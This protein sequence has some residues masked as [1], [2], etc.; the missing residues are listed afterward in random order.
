VEKMK[1]L[2]AA[3]IATRVFFAVAI[4][5]TYD[6]A[7]YW[8]W[9]K[10]LALGY[11]DHP[12]MV[13]WMIKISTLFFGDTNL[14]VRFF[15]IF[16]SILASYAVYY[17]GSLAVHK[18]AGEWAAI[19]LQ[20]TLLCGIG[21]FL[22]TPDVPL[23]VFWTLTLVALFKLT[24][25]G[26]GEWWLLI[27]LCAGLGFSSKYSAVFL[28][29]GILIIALKHLKNPWLYAGG[30]LALIAASP[31]LIWNIQHDWVSFIK[32]GSRVLIHEFNPVFTLEFLAGQGLLL[33]PIIAV[34]VI[35]GLFKLPRNKY[36]PILLITSAP[37]FIFLI[38]QS[39]FS[40]VE[41]NWASPLLPALIII[42]SQGLNK[43]YAIATG[44]TFSY[45]LLLF[46]WIKP[47]NLPPSL[48]D[49][50]Y[51][52]KKVIADIKNTPH[53]GVYTLHYTT[54]AWLRYQLKDIS[55][56]QQIGE[57]ERYLHE[58]PKKFTKAL[59][60]VEKKQ[61]HAVKNGKLLFQYA[62]GGSLFL[63]E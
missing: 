46:I 9:S 57:N 56:V 36:M 24:E 12:G 26:R 19:A 38:W 61:L 5:L 40:R 29:L 25:T 60:Y 35:M 53:D 54:N 41:G 58:T 3:F 31:P 7:Y 34:L 22:M 33:T 21:G 48:L 4:D 6:E 52:D 47:I 14:G 11:F 43:K 62:N 45:A 55:Q 51:L 13:A 28:G 32:Q 44:F 50:L 42:A 37:L 2:F 39:L 63:L 20:A 8:S 17:M 18:K 49:Q 27:G 10:N 1:W 30:L 16:F 23:L 59:L 15:P